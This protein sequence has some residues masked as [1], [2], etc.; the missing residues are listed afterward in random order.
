LRGLH[1]QVAPMQQAKLI[2]VTCGEIFDVAVD[3]R[4]TSASFGRWISTKL[5]AANR[6]QLW[7]PEGFAHGFYVTS[8]YADCVYKTTQYYSAAHE[9]RIAWNDPELGITWPIVGL[10]I[11]S[12]KDAHLGSFREVQ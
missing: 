11:L 6:F 1:Y 4:Q 9:R 8:D 10:P 3:L 7:L 12:S 2:R 5:S